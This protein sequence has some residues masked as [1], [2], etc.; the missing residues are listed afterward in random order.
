MTIEAIGAQIEIDREVV[1][2]CTI[3]LDAKADTSQEI[4]QAV[5]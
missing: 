4:H 2:S 3:S 1:I 5:K